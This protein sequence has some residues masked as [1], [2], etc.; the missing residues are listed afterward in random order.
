MDCPAG[1]EDRNLINILTGTVS[2]KAKCQDQLCVH[3]QITE[4]LNLQYV[5][6]IGKHISKTDD[7]Q[8][9]L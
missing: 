1:K 6:Y 9:Q 8:Y 3:K 7:T 5:T 4:T 2:P